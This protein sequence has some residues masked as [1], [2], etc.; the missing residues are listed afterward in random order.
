MQSST[1][2]MTA[3]L[4]KVL[5]CVVA[6]VGCVVVP[7]AA[8]AYET[9]GPEDGGYV[10][11]DEDRAKIEAALPDKAP[12]APKKARKLLIFDVNVVYGGH[13][14]RFYANLAFQ[15]MG[16]K[17]GAFE[18]VIS[19]DQTVFERE[20]LA[21]FDAVFPEQHGGQS[22]RGPEAPAE[23]GGVRIWRGRSHGR[24]RH[25]GGLL[26]LETG[27]RGRLARVRAH[28]RRPR[29]EPSRRP[30]ARLYEDRFAGP[31]A[32]SAVSERRL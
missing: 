20:N 17:T 23:P 7:R 10:I 22:V 19:R 29:G 1:G 11:S 27:R 6:A 26:E 16:K 3:G 25:V 28:A 9:G 30:G 8:L 13:P 4:A 5:G 12:V 18:V 24:A 32:R 15:E 21:E 2:R 14:S 31:S